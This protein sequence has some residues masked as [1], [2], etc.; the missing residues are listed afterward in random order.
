VAVI[1]NLD[2]VVPPPDKRVVTSTS[3][4]AVDDHIADGVSPVPALVAPVPLHWPELADVPGAPPRGQWER[5]LVLALVSADVI[6]LACAVTLSW[7]ARYRFTNEN[8]AFWGYR[9]PYGVLAL[10]ALPLWLCGLGVRGSYDR[11][12]IGSSPTEYS[13]VA[14]VVMGLLMLVCALSF[15][16]SVPVSRGL[17]AVFFP[18]L[19]VSS[20]MGRYGVRKRLH[21]RRALGNA[22]RR[23]VL[24][25]D[26]AAVSNLTTHLRRSPHAGYE[27]VGAYVPGGSSVVFDDLDL[28]VLGEPDQL[29]S[30]ISQQEIDA[31]AVSGHDLFEHESLRSL[32]WKLH[33]TGI[34]LLMAPDMAEIAGPR[35]VSRPAGGLP[36]LLVE[37]PRTGGPAQF[38]KALTE[39]GAAALA[40]LVLS[41]VLAAIA[42]AVKLTSP[43]P[44]LFRQTRVARD[45]NEFDML[46][47]RSMVDGAD[48]Q[49]DELIDQN[50]HDGVLFKIREDP[51]IT[52]AGRFIRRYSLDELP[53]L[54]NVV[55][56]D[57]SIV[58]PRPPLPS[59][60]SQYGG[61]VGRRLM[62]KPGITGLWQVSGRSDL[63][64]DESVRL[65]LY[66]VENW[67]LTLDL[68]IV[69]KTV[70]AV[71][72]GSGAY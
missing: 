13:R 45:G 40:L 39:R 27:V 17:I 33:G 15:V 22:L 26:R 4:A 58:G 8:L 20:V 61:D 51:R 57:M 66:Y 44:V 67:S 48:E 29:V 5:K 12:I 54:W 49:V 9:F 37:E 42:V 3:P 53:Q 6:A 11:S 69:G 46:K 30:D 32:A 50:D 2:H 64:W 31:V 52:P 63:S 34:Q 59:E 24:V 23:V 1:E 72:A 62:V 19:L 38:L 47:F 18:A 25:G 21:H 7:L 14:G 65:D 68:V 41:P 35:I 28:E 71:L 55:R 16:G 36:M 43:G 10:V 56:G 60:V 70:K